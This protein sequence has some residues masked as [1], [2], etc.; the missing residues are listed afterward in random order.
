MHSRELRSNLNAS[1]PLNKIAAAISL[2]RKLPDKA[3]EL[4]L[5]EKA[6]RCAALQIVASTLVNETTQPDRGL[7]ELRSILE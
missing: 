5:E 7:T 1:P 2:H 6:I 4:A 3:T